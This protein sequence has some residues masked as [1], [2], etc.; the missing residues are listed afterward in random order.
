MSY[1]MADA[2][3]IFK[4][5]FKDYSTSLKNTSFDKTNS[6]YLCND[7]TMLVYDFDRLVKDR[8]PLKQPSSYD[9]LLID[10]QKIFCI[11]FKNEKYSNIDNKEVSK[12][13][14]N[15]KDVL[16]S[17][18]QKNHIQLRDYTFIYCVAYK[19]TQARWKRGISKA[20]IQFDL[21]KYQPKYFNKIYTNDIMFFTNEYKKYFSKALEC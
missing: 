16:T 3:S 9:A 2:Q 13:L 20:T 4:K 6:V 21:E 12:K 19:N 1:K 17:I 10:K 11:E 7:K 8:Y 14:K 15:G 5:D 18:F